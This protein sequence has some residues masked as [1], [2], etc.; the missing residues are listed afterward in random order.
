M[1]T[2]EQYLGKKGEN[3]SPVRED[4]K[5]PERQ[6]Q[7]PKNNLVISWMNKTYKRESTKLNCYASLL[8][9]L[10]SFYG[11][12]KYPPFSKPYDPPERLRIINDGIEH[13]LKENRDFA[14]DFISH[15]HWLN[16]NKYA[17]KT[18]HSSTNLIKKFFSRHG[19]KLSDEEEEDSFRLLSPNKARTRDEVL[20]KEQFRSVLCHLGTYMR[21]LALFLLS[22]GARVGAALKLK[23]ADLDLD[24][25]PPQ[26]NIRAEYTKGEYGGRIMW[27]SYE[28]RDALREWFKVKDSRL[29]KTGKTFPKEMVFGIQ[30]NNARI[31]W[32]NALEK[33]G[34]DQRDSSTKKKIYIYHIHAIR[35]FFNTQMLSDNVSPNVVQ[36]W[37]GHKA[38][39]ASSYDRFTE[40][41]LAKIYLEHMDAVSIY[42]SDAETEQS[43][44]IIAEDE[45]NSYLAAGWTFKATLASGKNVIEGKRGLSKLPPKEKTAP[46]IEEKPVIVTTKKPEPPAPPESKPIAPPKP[47]SKPQRSQKI[48][49]E[50]KKELVKED[51]KLIWCPYKDDWIDPIKC[52]TCKALRF[53]VYADCKR[54]RI[55]NPNDSLFDPDKPRPLGQ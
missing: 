8:R 7:P 5:K 52:E 31:L 34:L 43:Q 42:V 3:L 45:L 41:E 26:V 33:T 54:R 16:K 27:M 23:I 9:F 13:Y 36:K 25:D 19:H 38:Y 32:I 4:N 18:C 22:T 21:P 35:K 20:T 12:Q 17:P 40:K 37:I 15:I 39:L 44:R 53:K 29:K 50:T 6:T 2:L 47:V 11:E 1:P 30:R 55:L 14:E 49:V 46:V 48:H 51:S 10:R 24:H 28:A